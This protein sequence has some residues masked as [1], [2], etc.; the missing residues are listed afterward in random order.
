MAFIVGDM[1]VGQSSGAIGIV[2][3]VVGTAY[4]FQMQGDLQ[5]EPSENINNLTDGG[6]IGT[7]GE[8]IIPTYSL[9]GHE[10]G[11]DAIISGNILAIKSYFTT[12]DFGFPTG[13]LDINSREGVNNWTRLTRIEP[14]FVQSGNM[15]IEVISKEF[16]NSSDVV[17]TPHVFGPTTEKI[18][19]RVQAR[20]IRLRFTSNTQGGNYEMGR[21]LMHTE[22]GDNRT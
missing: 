4:Y 9:Y 13:G 2:I 17:S 7:L 11:K 20:H 3:Q 6:S 22:V 12:H 15:T 1:V 18:D 5:F 10:F 21:T 19:M 16:G 14:D 8:T